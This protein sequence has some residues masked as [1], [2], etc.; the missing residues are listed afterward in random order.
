MGLYVAKATAQSEDNKDKT[1]SKKPNPTPFISADTAYEA[2]N[3][4]RKWMRPYFEPLDEFE[5]IARNR[6]SPKIPANMPKITDGT[7]AAIVQ[8][9]P[10]RIIQQIATGQ[11][12]CDDY[13]EYAKIADLVHTRTLIPNYNRM[14]DALQKHWNMLGK[15]MT[16]GRATSYTFFTSTNGILHTDFN[17][18]YAKDV[19]S[20]KG[21]VFAADSNVRFM[22]SWYQKHDLTAIIEKEQRMEKAIKGYKSDWDIPELIAFREAGPSAKPAD[23]QTPAEREKGGDV[24]GYEVIHAFQRGNAA[25]FYSFAPKMQD[26][27]GQNKNKGM[28]RTKKNKD[29]RGLMPLDDLYCNIDLSNPMGRGQVELSGGVQNLIDQ[30]M[31]MFQFMMT[32]MMGPPLQVWGNVNKASLKFLPNSI[33]D[34]GSMATNKVE[35]YSINNEGINNFPNNYGLL[36]SQ[37]LN[38]NSSQDNSISAESGNPQQS[39][40]QA[41]VQQQAARLGVSDNYL[42]K[43]FEAWFSRQS[44]TSI[45]VHFAEMTGKPTMRLEGEELKEVLKTPAAKF[46]DKQGILTIPYKE[47]SEVAFKFNV[48]A[49]SSEVKEDADNADKLAQALEIIQKSQDQTVRQAE[50]KVTKLLLDQIGAEGTDDLFPQLDQKDANGM[51]IEGQPAQPDP[52]AILQ[53]IAPAIQEMVQQGI[54]QAMNSQDNAVKVQQNELKGREIDLKERQFQADTILK[55]DKQAHDTNL[56]VANHAQGVVSAEQQAQQ[57]QQ[58]AEQQAAAQSQPQQPEQQPQS[59]SDQSLDPEEQKIVHSLFQ[60]GFNE[61]DIEQAIM[62]LRQGMTLQQIIQTLGA[63]YAQR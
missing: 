2:Y 23:Q 38:L 18:P 53:Q 17:I 57:Q 13:P 63:K 59:L 55:A 30:Q 1:G 62:M 31:Q 22:R 45:N 9:Q 21:K 39:K 36:K 52:N 42:R 32:M 35:A 12:E 27:K 41:G 5:R 3:E 54:Q 6:P 8:E 10:K 60:R 26:G 56:A 49:S 16:Y 4:T 43:Q 50:V 25:N 29:P 48:D 24:G 14:G 34:M 37:I 33:W 40:T 46:V 44:E 19:Y 51:P 47:I 20:E 58:Q 15:A 11:V 61:H 7:M 28:L